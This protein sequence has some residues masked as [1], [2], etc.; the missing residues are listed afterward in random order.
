MTTR[1]EAVEFCLHQIAAGLHCMLA[2]QR[3]TR[4]QFKERLRA[5]GFQNLEMVDAALSATV[6][7]GYITARDLAD[8]AFVLECEWDFRIYKPAQD[9]PTPSELE[10]GK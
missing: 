8:M 9:E 6:D 3:V 10:T 7:A 2:L 5:I 4:S 1:E